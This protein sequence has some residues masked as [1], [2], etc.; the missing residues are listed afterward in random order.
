LIF[1]FGDS[2]P[3]Q[4][5]SAH[6]SILVATLSREKKSFPPRNH[7]VGLARSLEARRKAAKS[8]DQLIWDWLFNI[9]AWYEPSSLREFVE[10]L[11]EEGVPTRRGG[12]WT[13]G[14]VHAHLEKHKVSAKEFVNRVTQPSAYESHDF[15][16]EVYAQWR[17]AVDAIDQPSERTGKWVPV[18]H[19][20]PERAD[21]VRHINA[22]LRE[23][24]GEGQIVKSVS[25]FCYLCRFLGENGTFDVECA[26][27][28][29]EVF[30]YARSREER[31][32]AT[33]RLSNRFFARK[34]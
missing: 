15:P 18:T 11:N 6:F 4:A 25:P 1:N 13:T 12:S 29:I 19:V 14:L 9:A 5:K 30:K 22:E 32:A 10:R 20:E 16:T 31:I 26:A 8:Y 7:E 28:D 33:E 2:H 23:R 24:F 34:D 3:V 17:K 27:A 21:L